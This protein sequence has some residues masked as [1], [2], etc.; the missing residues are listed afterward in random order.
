MLYGT[1]STCLHQPRVVLQ[2]RAKFM[3]LRLDVSMC[4]CWHVAHS[5]RL[6]M[7]CYAPFRQQHREA[8]IRE[9]VV[10]K[11]IQKRYAEKVRNENQRWRVQ[12][13]VRLRKKKKKQEVCKQA[14]SA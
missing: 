8:L 12:L 4:L 1:P 9:P 3:L 6:H 13:N 10:A 7:E 2:Y 14:V 5:L 11:K